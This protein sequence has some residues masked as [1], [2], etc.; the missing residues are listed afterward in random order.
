MRFKTKEI[1]LA[2][3]MAALMVV[4]TVITRIPFVNAVVPFSFQPLVAVLAG[5]LLGARTGA[6]SVLV[7]LLLGLAGLP[8]FAT[9]PFG[10]LMYVLKPTFGFLVGQVAAAYV[11]GKLLENRKAGLP[12]YIIASL[13][14]MAVIYL[15]GLPYL[16]AALNFYLGKATS[17][18]RV[19][20][21]GFIPYVLWDLLKGIVVAII[22][23]AV[24]R[25]LPECSTE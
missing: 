1:A 2:G 11:A 3:L 7:Y 12:R 9:E 6:L 22:A 13:A 14:G 5:T 25:R 21:I 15:V 16:Y 17:V 8:V 18:M 10:G 19:L 20:Q 24:H 4:V 23:R